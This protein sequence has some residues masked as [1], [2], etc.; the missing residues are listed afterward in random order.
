PVK[1]S[2]PFATEGITDLF[3]TNRYFLWYH[4]PFEDFSPLLDQLHELTPTQPLGLSEYGAGAALTH[5][6]DNPRGG[7]P[8]VHGAP[9]PEEGGGVSYQP[10][11][12][13]AF[14]HEQNYSVIVTKPY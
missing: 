8:E 5:H 2:G 11:E 6:T 10:E 13:A 14:A 12:Y 7:E 9:R 1:R 3:A 4:L